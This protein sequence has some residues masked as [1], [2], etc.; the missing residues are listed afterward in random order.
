MHVNSTI[1]DCEVCIGCRNT[2]HVRCNTAIGLTVDVNLNIIG[3][4]NCEPQKH[5]LVVA[6]VCAR[7]CAAASGYTGSGVYLQLI[8]V[9]SEVPVSTG[10]CATSGPGKPVSGNNVPSRTRP[11]G[12]ALK[13][14]FKGHGSGKCCRVVSTH[15]HKSRSR[16]G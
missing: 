14:G 8:V 1:T 4:I 10:D 16:R 6:T 12:G 9:D 13:P 5:P 2:N 3:R 11:I 15:A 7:E